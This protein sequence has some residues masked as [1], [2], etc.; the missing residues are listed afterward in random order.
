[1]DKSV[2]NLAVGRETP[3]EWYRRR[4]A[5]F[6]SRAT[7]QGLG[8][9]VLF[10]VAAT[11]FSVLART[12]WIT[13]EKD[14]QFVSNLL[15]AEMQPGTELTQGAVFSVLVTALD[16]ETLAGALFCGE[17]T[18]GDCGAGLE[19]WR[20]TQNATA[21]PSRIPAP[22]PAPT[23]TP[24]PVPTPA[25]IP[26]PGATPCTGED[27]DHRR[28]IRFRLDAPLCEGTD[29]TYTIQIVPETV[30][31]EARPPGASVSLLRQR[32]QDARAVG[33]DFATAVEKLSKTWEPSK[34]ADEAPRMV[35]AYFVSID[36]VLQYWSRDKGRFPGELPTWRSWAA[37][38]YF[39]RLVRELPP[40]GSIETKPYLD[41]AGNGIIYTR[42]H[43]VRRTDA[44][45]ELIMLGAVCI[46]YGLTDLSIRKLV[47]AIDRSP[48]SEA[49]LVVYTQQADQSW[50]SRHHLVA[51]GDTAS[52]A[53]VGSLQ[54][55]SR[56]RQ[57]IEWLPSAWQDGDADRDGI[58]PSPDDESLFFARLGKQSDGASIGVAFRIVG[59]GPFGSRPYLMALAALSFA[60]AFGAYWT[61]VGSSRQIARRENL[62]GRLR[63][64]QVG[65]LQSDAEDI[66]TAGND[67]A[68]ELV[69]RSLP[70][71]GLDHSRIYFWDLFDRSRIMRIS[72]GAEG[73]SQQDIQEVDLERTK[74]KQIQRE[75]LRG[76]TTIYYVRLLRPSIRTEGGV[77]DD[78]LRVQAG[79][80]IKPLDDRKPGMSL[81]SALR[82]VKQ[83]LSGTFGILESVDA[84]LA[85]LLE[86]KSSECLEGE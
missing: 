59:I 2:P 30:A 50:L 5:S 21:A 66:I 22:P 14:R 62:L 86:K 27:R 35:A 17:R 23:P 51:D 44:V 52:P 19:L 74:A 65:V 68:E 56:E 48:L 80:V 84:A 53:E 76:A 16:H 6:F 1:M 72:S 18:S 26:E 78:W 77:A 58:I 15:R 33:R 55:S 64:L 79:P 32:I 13:S 85:Q 49:A 71:F 83:D 43:A 40:D 39:E 46:D 3:P 25:E 9:F 8:P 36:S 57:W 61:G 69:R 38:P 11:L 73:K 60:I 45:Q 34:A 67:R 20:A 31:G 81:Q 75:R 12:V 42:C 41:F 54:F 63:S 24:T 4:L 10:A 37:R 7:N 47:E 28:R 29:A 82:N 70:T